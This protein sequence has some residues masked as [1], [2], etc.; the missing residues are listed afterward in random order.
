ML[1]EVGV[2]N[3]GEEVEGEVVKPLPEMGDVVVKASGR[4]G[5]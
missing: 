1:A 5:V 2:R 4:S 3:G